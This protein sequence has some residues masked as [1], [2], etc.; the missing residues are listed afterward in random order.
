MHSS[1]ITMQVSQIQPVLIVGF[2]IL[3]M[4]IFDKTLECRQIS[5]H[6]LEICIWDFGFLLDGCPI[7]K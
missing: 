7:C 4:N 3:P 6:H 5:E 1:T 2:H